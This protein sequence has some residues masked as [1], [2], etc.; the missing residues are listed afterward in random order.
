MT[1][2]IAV[3][4]A[5]LAVAVLLFAWDRVAADVVALGVM[6]AVIAT[7]LLPA[8]QAF[9]G[10]SSDTVMM[11]LGLLVMSAGL[12]QTGVVEIAGRYVFD[13]AGRNAAVFLPVIMLAVAAVSAFMS[14]TAATAFFVPLVIGYASRIGVSPS[15]FLLPLAFSS[16]LTSS[17][18]LISTSTNLVVSDLLTRYQQPPMGMFELAPVGIPIAVVGILYVWVVGVRLIPQRENQKAE[19]QQSGSASIRQMW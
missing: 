6:L 18:T 4:L 19:E 16:I 11:I 13:L 17:V 9:A 2:D 8:D 5:I 3:C 1:P 14:N 7:G 10:F 12:I 15:R